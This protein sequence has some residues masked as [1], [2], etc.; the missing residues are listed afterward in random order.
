MEI[1]PD[2]KAYLHKRQHSRHVM[3]SALK[4]D[5]DGQLFDQRVEK[6]QVIRSRSATAA[7]TQ[8]QFLED[9][10]AELE[11]ADLLREKSVHTFI[12]H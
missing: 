2:F 6:L 10:T 7:N 4:H 1:D 12:N 5:E 8:I 3:S 9:R 11:T